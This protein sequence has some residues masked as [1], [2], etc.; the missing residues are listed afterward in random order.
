MHRSFLTQTSIL[1]LG[2][3]IDPAPPG[4]FWPILFPNTTMYMP[5]NE[6]Y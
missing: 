5:Q 1:D 6:T 4:G 2:I 3:A